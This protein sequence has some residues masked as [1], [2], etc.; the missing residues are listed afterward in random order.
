MFLDFKA[1]VYLVQVKKLFGNDTYAMNLPFHE[2]AFPC[3]WSLYIFHNVISS[4]AS[5]YN[6]HW[7]IKRQKR[8]ALPASINPRRVHAST[9]KE[10]TSPKYYSL[11]SL[12]AP[13]KSNLN[14]SNVQ[15]LALDF[16]ADLIDKCILYINNCRR[17]YIF[18]CL[19]G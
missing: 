17:I 8:G 6:V 16:M 18:P 15:I 19:N 12:T 10:W 9:Q 2:T 4:A 7:K 11:S 5:R 3:H 13:K 14:L 1:P